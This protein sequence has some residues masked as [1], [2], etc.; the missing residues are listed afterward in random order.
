MESPDQLLPSIA[1]R[2][3]ADV[4]TEIRA[5]STEEFVRF[6]KLSY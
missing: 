5:H 4:I 6:Y 2:L 3:K 1:H